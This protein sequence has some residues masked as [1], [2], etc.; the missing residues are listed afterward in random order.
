MA[1]I[2]ARIVVILG[3]REPRLPVLH[4]STARSETTL[5]RMDPLLAKRL[6]PIGSGPGCKEAR[7]GDSLFTLRRVGWH[8]FGWARLIAFSRALQEASTPGRGCKEARFGDSL[9]TLRRVGWHLL[10][11]SQTRKDIPMAETPAAGRPLL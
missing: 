10:G 8:L 9:F 5:A 3:R 1:P 7:F 4:A 6:A 11:W 2:L